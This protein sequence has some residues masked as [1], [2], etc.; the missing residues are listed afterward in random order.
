MR[1]RLSLI[2]SLH[3]A[4]ETGLFMSKASKVWSAADYEQFIIYIAT[5]PRAVVGD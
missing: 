3:T 1:Y 2:G 4:I 5:N